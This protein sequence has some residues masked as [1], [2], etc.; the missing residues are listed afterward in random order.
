MNPTLT[1]LLAA[2]KALLDV[3]QSE[4]A[5]GLISTD[6]LRKAGEIQLMISKFEAGSG[7]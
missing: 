2:F 4:A 5:S 1:S 3:I 6:T 7:Q